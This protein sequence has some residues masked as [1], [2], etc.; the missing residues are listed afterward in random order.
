MVD[1]GKGVEAKT[2]VGE[3]GVLPVFEEILLLPPLLVLALPR[4]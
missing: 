3:V 1:K 4:A 2:G